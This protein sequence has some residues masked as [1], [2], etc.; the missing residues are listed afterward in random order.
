MHCIRHNSIVTLFIIMSTVNGIL[1]RKVFKFDELAYNLCNENMQ[2][3]GS[4]IQGSR[5]NKYSISTS[6]L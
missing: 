5:Y 6:V 4:I 2:L 3:H 1:R